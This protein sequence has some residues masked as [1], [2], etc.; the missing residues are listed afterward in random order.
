MFSKTRG[1]RAGSMSNN[2]ANDSR[3]TPLTTTKSASK[4]AE[5]TWTAVKTAVNNAEK[6]QAAAVEKLVDSHDLF[7]DEKLPAS[8]YA[9]VDY[10]ALNTYRSSSKTLPPTK[11]CR[12]IASFLRN[13]PL[14][15]LCLNKIRDWHLQYEF[16]HRDR[17]IE[18]CISFFEDN[19]A[20]TK[21]SCLIEM[22]RISGQHEPFQRL[23]EILRQRYEVGVVLW[24]LKDMH[25]RRI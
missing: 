22:H 5:A 13:S 1:I 21:E 19:I 3:L 7:F 24:F 18:F 11:L 15:D 4:Q 12:A 16:F 25:S 8:P 6:K 14:V 17:K 9:G 23:A 2:R 20:P 10:F